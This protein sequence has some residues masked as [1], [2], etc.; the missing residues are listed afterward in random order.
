MDNKK[1]I[2]AYIL[3]LVLVI[4]FSATILLANVRATVLNTSNVKNKIAQ[5]NYYD[6]VYGIIVSSCEN[7]IMQSGFENSI[8][9]DV[10]SKVNVEK[11]IEAVIDYVYEGKEYNIQT[12]DIKAKLNENIEKYIEV[13]NYAVS[14]ENKKSIEQFETTIENTYRRNIEYSSDMVNEIASYVKK[15]KGMC[16]GLTIV[17]AI[18]S[19]ALFVVIY[20]LCKPAVGIGMLATGAL[21]IFLKCCSGVNVAVN[22]ILIMNK[23]FSDTIISIV[24]NLLQ[25]LCTIGVILAVGGVIWIFVYEIKRNIVRMLLLEEHSQVIR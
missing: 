25:N 9:V 14:E 8:L 18:V 1:R 5:A 11:D 19:I 17:S 24:N 6:E 4:F 22:N 20:R 10:I 23:S 13:N 3:S 12:A 2:I 15:A 7:Y 16:T 21:F